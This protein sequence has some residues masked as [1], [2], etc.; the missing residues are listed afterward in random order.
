MGEEG[1][2]LRST[3]RYLQN[4][5]GDVKYSRGNGEAK[6]L[7]RMT[8]GHE[9]W[10]GDCLREECV[11]GFWVEGKKGGKIGTTIIA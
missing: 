4:S 11:G 6:E 1:R 5:H 10:C 9:Q 8:C 3:N 2:R 7:I